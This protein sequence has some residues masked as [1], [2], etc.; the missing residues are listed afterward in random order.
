MPAFTDRHSAAAHLASVFASC[1]LHKA[2]VAPV[3]GCVYTQLLAS[4]RAGKGAPCLVRSV[5]RGAPCVVHFEED[6][7]LVAWEAEGAPRVLVDGDLFFGAH[8][9]CGTLA[10]AAAGI[11]GASA[12]VFQLLQRG[13][14]YSGAMACALRER[15]RRLQLAGSLG[16]WG[17]AWGMGHGCLVHGVGHGHHGELR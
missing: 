2:T 17:W 9:L 14:S 15:E 1:A 10:D 8:A 3:E 5:E 6:G 16:A 12:D 7:A 11:E 4:L 13:L